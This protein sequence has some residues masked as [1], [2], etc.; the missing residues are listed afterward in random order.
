MTGGADPEDAWLRWFQS[1]TD[2]EKVE[3][4]LRWLLG[5]VDRLAPEV[6]A[7]VA[8]KGAAVAV[9]DVA[10]TLRA[11]G[12]TSGTAY[13]LAA[14]L[15]VERSTY[16]PGRPPGSSGRPGRLVG[17]IWRVVVRVIRVA[18]DHLRGGPDKERR[19]SDAPDD[20]RD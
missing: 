8:E 20:E 18:V 13:T 4:D 6:R 7:L 9:G 15:M 1:R 10:G 11:C 12:L 17:H 5:A 19:R 2:H 14:A 3:D 16:A